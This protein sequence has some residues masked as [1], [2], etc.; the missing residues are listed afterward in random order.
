MDTRTGVIVDESSI[1]EEDK[2]HYVPLTNQ[3]VKKYQKLKPS[4][5]MGQFRLDQD[6]HRDRQIT[7]RREANK[8]NK[9]SRKGK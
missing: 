5:R 4:E 9:Q 6:K 8:R 7:K 2:H 3:Q 1:P